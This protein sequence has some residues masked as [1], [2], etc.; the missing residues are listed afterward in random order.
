VLLEAPNF[1]LPK[2]YLTELSQN[3]FKPNPN[4]GD[5]F[6]ILSLQN[7]IVAIHKL[8]ADGSFTEQINCI[9]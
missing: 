5:T 8:A 2:K 6:S 4:G 1:L 7:S 9:S 3:F